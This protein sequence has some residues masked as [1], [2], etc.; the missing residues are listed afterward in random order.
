MCFL[1]I[2]G[3][4][5]VCVYTVLCC[6]FM[7]RTQ[8][9][10]SFG[11]DVYGSYPN[12]A[13]M[14]AMM[15][16]EQTPPACPSESPKS[17]LI[18]VLD[19]SLLVTDMD[20]TA[21]H[22]IGPVVGRSLVSAD[23]IPAAVRLLSD[24]APYGCELDSVLSDGVPSKIFCTLYPYY[25]DS[26]TSEPASSTG[27]GHTPNRVLWTMRECPSISNEAQIATMIRFVVKRVV[28][29]ARIR[30]SWADPDRCPN[31]LAVL[32]LALELFDV[33]AMTASTEVE[34]VGSLVNLMES[35]LK[36]VT[37]IEGSLWN[38]HQI[39]MLEA[40]ADDSSLIATSCDAMEGGLV[41]PVAP[42]LQLPSQHTDFTPLERE[43]FNGPNEP[44]G[45][46]YIATD[47]VLRRKHTKSSDNIDMSTLADM[48]SS[49]D[50]FFSQLRDPSMCPHIIGLLRIVPSAAA[51]AV[52]EEFITHCQ[53]KHTDPKV[54][55][56]M[57][58]AQEMVRTH[59]LE[60]AIEV[61][62]E[63][64]MC[65]MHC[66]VSLQGNHCL[67]LLCIYPFTYSHIYPPIYSFM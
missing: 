32:R 2:D 64:N 12:I 25:D 55:I 11:S 17:T 66:H 40:C 5:I 42:M 52:V 36:W 46:V 18:T 22:R 51:A 57:K 23:W 31:V 33:D 59:R 47:D 14:R 19:E 4:L 67:P 44:V 13:R 34:E 65:R 56:L 45:S 16:Q 3:I 21:L 24:W 9:L 54:Q 15:Q 38:L 53:T 58:D 1:S 30:I 27:A 50:T 43:Y 39:E 35:F 26:V 6:V 29:S 62:D 63:V 8:L 49:V 41:A 60:M 37:A 48:S 10:A 7:R 20:A 61:L 28:D